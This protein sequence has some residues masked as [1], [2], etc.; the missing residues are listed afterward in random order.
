MKKLPKNKT[1]VGIA[2]AMASQW[3]PYIKEAKEEARCIVY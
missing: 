1:F 3:L 2:E